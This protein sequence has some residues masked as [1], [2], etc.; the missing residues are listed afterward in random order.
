MKT[1]DPKKAIVLA[2][3]AVAVITAAVVRSL[4]KSGNSSKV[5]AGGSAQ[6]SSS[7]SPRSGGTLPD[8]VFSNPFYH[9][10]LVIKKSGPGPANTEEAAIENERRPS[11][12]PVLKPMGGQLPNVVAPAIPED[13]NRGSQQ[14]KQEPKKHSIA[15][16]AVLKASSCRAMISVDGGA[17]EGKEKGDSVLGGIITVVDVQETYVIFKTAD[18]LKKI[19]VGRQLQI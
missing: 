3:V 5:V 6:T 8:N 10:N 16:E 18:G 19:S 11:E 15:V 7:P 9:A 17:P 4:P 14:S 13:V 1:G 2:A 12:R